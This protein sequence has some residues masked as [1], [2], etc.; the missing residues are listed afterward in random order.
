MTYPQLEELQ[1]IRTQDF[2]VV[3]RLKYIAKKSQEGKLCRTL[4]LE[5][6]GYRK[7]FSSIYNRMFL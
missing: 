6:N 4:E 2:T 7:N 5:L 1:K 3:Q